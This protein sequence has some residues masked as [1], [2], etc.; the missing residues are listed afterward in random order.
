MTDSI[1]NR[2]MPRAAVIPVLGYADVTRA[3]TWLCDAFGFR[4]RL[5]IGGHRVQLAIGEDGV[6]VAAE[7]GRR[8]EEPA[9]ADATH[10]VMVRVADVDAHHAHAVAHGARVTSEPTTYPYGERQYSALD[11]EGYAWTFSQSVA[12]VDPATWGGELLES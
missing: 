12:D 4:V 2:A 7:R 9:T 10:S 3:A 11:P 8:A 6:V 1:R 5:R